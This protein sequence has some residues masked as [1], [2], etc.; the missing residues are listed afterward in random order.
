MKVL[1]EQHA[2]QTSPPR[3]I[4]GCARASQPVSLPEDSGGGDGGWP[5]SLGPL[6]FPA[7]VLGACAAVTPS[8]VTTGKAPDPGRLSPDPSQA[9]WRTWPR[10]LPLASPPRP[11]PLVFGRRWVTAVAASPTTCPLPGP[12]PEGRAGD[13]IQWA[14]PRERSLCPHGPAAS[15][16]PRAP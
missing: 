13:S 5:P 4:R 14:L 7:R 11:A 2:V 1:E 12:P 16:G 8:S 6:W 9:F 15:H 10:L 3:S